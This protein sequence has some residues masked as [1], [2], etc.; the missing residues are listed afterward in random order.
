MHGR[1]QVR[2]TGQH[3]FGSGNGPHR[4]EQRRHR[5]ERPG[6]YFWYVR[7][8]FWCHLSWLDERRVSSQAEKYHVMMYAVKE[9]IRIFLI[10][11]D[12]SHQQYT[13]TYTITR[14]STLSCFVHVRT[15]ASFITG[16]TC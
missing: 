4:R 6:T 9:Y 2:E 14:S 8:I 1:E 12:G 3:V 16:V 15:G 11:G 5:G 10:L 7:Q 13:Q